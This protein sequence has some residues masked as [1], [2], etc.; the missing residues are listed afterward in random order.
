M[1]WFRLT[2]LV[3]CAAPCAFASAVVSYDAPGVE[4]TN[5]AAASIYSFNNLSLNRAVLPATAFATF[6][7]LYVIGANEYGGAHNSAYGVVGDPTGSANV[8][9]S[10][11][12]FA[13]PVSYL[14]FWWS[15]ADPNNVFTLYNG[16]DP[17]LTMT[18]QTLMNALGSCRA[19][20]AYCG[21][22]N[23]G[24][25]PGELFAYVNIWGA[26]GLTFT[27][28]RFH[29]MNDSGGFEFD[30]V[31][32]MDD[33]VGDPPS[34]VPEPGTWGFAGL[35]FVAISMLAKRAGRA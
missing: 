7:Q 22:P 35:G 19:S 3:L 10:F 21:N 27:A 18:N 31:A 4:D 1:K 14:G 26:N 24:Q 15:A 6:S 13:R 33:P 11:L 32:Y 29:Q 23:N 28:A 2:T 9:T 20:N 17:L 5:V 16:R 25:D 30:N 34:S 8:Q 12:Q